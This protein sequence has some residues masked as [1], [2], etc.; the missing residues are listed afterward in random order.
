[1]CFR[2]R[3]WKIEKRF[4]K[5]LN[6]LNTISKIRIFSGFFTPLWQKT[7]Y[8]WVLDKCHH[9][10]WETLTFFF[11]H[12]MEQTTNL[13]KGDELWAY[14]F[15]FNE[16]THDLIVEVLDGSPL[17]ALLNILF[18]QENQKTL[19]WTRRQNGAQ[20]KTDWNTF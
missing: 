19:E 16:V 9:G 1:M 14:Q 15:I 17:D 13:L 2:N 4:K 3:R 7:D 5:N 10:L 20:R 11:Y 6:S 8:L 18:L 12:F